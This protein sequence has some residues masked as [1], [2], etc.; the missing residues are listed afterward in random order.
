M[1]LE[2]EAGPDG[3]AALASLAPLSPF[4]ELRQPLELAANQGFFLRP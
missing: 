1:R 2:A 3:A 4:C